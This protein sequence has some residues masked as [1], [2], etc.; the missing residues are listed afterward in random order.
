[1]STRDAL[2]PRPPPLRGPSGRSA[3]PAPAA[4]PR[5]NRP[6]RAG[7]RGCASATSGRSAAAASRRSPAFAASAR[8]LLRRDGR[9]RLEDDRR[10]LELGGRLGQGLQ[11]R[12]GRR[13]RRRGVG[14]ERRLRRDGGGADPRQRL[15]RRRRLQVD[16]R[17]EGPGR[18]SGSARH[19]QISRVRVHPK[20]PGPRLR[21][22]ARARLGPNAER[23]IFRSKDGG[24]T[25]DEVL[26]V[27]RE[28]GRV[29]PR[30]G[31]D[32][33]AHPLRRLLAGRDGGRGSSSRGGP[34]S[35]L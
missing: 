5:R 35:G 26:F 22:G 19:A 24:K 28:D 7:W 4:A 12:L 10:R 8:L 9:R 2:R 1:M 6:S 29:R 33:P 25:W 15:A 27:E 32:E 20:E 11:D 23:G 30:H 18:T 16:R 13:D 34:G 31:P 21:R 17:R 14:S 3:A